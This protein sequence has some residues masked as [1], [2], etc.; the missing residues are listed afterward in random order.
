MRYPLPTRLLSVLLSSAWLAGCQADLP[1]PVTPT[2]QAQTS[3]LTYYPVDTPEPFSEIAAADDLVHYYGSPTLG[4][5]SATNSYGGHAIWYQ[6]ATDYD[7]TPVWQSLNG[8]DGGGA[9]KIAMTG[10]GNTMYV[11]NDQNNLYS[12]SDGTNYWYQYPYAAV[13]VATYNDQYTYFLGAANV[14]G[15]HPIYRLLWNGDAYEVTSGAGAVSLAVDYQGRPWVVNDA[16][17]IFVGPSPRIFPNGGGSFTQYQGHGKEIACSSS[18]TLVARGPA[19]TNGFPIYS[20]VSSTSPSQNNWSPQGG[21]AV[22]L[23]GFGAYTLF[24]VGADGSL[25]RGEIY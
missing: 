2:T 19:G 13:D 20:Q 11:V 12:Q 4:A 22:Q 7:Q 3:A 18:T 5:L 9:T 14:P 6:L 15:G 25:L 17:Q 10:L 21:E 24:A 1:T 8:P 16:D 23:A